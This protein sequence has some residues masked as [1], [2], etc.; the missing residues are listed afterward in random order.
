M[1]TTLIGL[2]FCFFGLC[3]LSAGF[4]ALGCVVRGITHMEK[5]GTQIPSGVFLALAWG[6]SALLWWLGLRLLL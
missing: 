6:A 3:F 4:V 2:V 1:A 5:G